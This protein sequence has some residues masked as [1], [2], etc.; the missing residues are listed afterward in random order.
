MR[1]A[2]SSRALGVVVG[3]LGVL[4]LLL[5]QMQPAVA[6]VQGAEGDPTLTIVSSHAEAV[7]GE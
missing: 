3:F 6:A 7:R 5:A 1:I 2:N 4:L